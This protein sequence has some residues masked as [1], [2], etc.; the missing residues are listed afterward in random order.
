MSTKY[1]EVQKLNKEFHR[2]TTTHAISELGVHIQSPDRYG[3]VSSQLTA[4]LV[5]PAPSSARVFASF[6]HCTLAEL[7]V[8]IVLI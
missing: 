8:F 2:I 1:L 3:Q 4:D 6:I 5:F 7:F